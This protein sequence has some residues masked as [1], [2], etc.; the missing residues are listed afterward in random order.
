MQASKGTEKQSVFGSSVPESAM[1]ELSVGSEHA[2]LRKSVLGECGGGGPQGPARTGAG[3]GGGGLQE[4]GRGAPGQSETGPVAARA[5]A[6]RGRRE[7][8][9][10]GAGPDVSA[11]LAWAPALDS[12]PVP[13][14]AAPLRSGSG[15]PPAGLGWGSGGGTSCA[16]PPG[17]RRAPWSAP[18]LWSWRSPSSSALLRP[19]LRQVSARWSDRACPAEPPGPMA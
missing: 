11:P 13:L 14:R 12:A 7:T 10:P 6:S 2:G 8:A 19:R 3:L 16:G 4:W 18:R 15:S 17:R 1:P 9:E 5:A